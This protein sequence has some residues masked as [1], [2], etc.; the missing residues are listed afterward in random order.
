MLRQITHITGCS[1]DDCGTS[2]DVKLSYAATKLDL[3]QVRTFFAFRYE[4]DML[5]D[6]FI[7]FVRD[8]PRLCR[9]TVSTAVLK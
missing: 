4:I 3:S 6:V 8:S 7:R 9:L 1:L 5:N 2:L